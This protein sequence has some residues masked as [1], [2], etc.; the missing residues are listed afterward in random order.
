M[1]NFRIGSC[2]IDAQPYLH[3]HVHNTKQIIITLNYLINSIDKTKYNLIHNSILCDSVIEN[4]R[5]NLKNA[6]NIIIEI[7]SLKLWKDTN[8]NYIHWGNYNKDNSNYYENI[9]E[10]DF[11]NDLYIIYEILKDKNIIFVSHINLPLNNF[12]NMVE[13]NGE[14]RWLSNNFINKKERGCEDKIIKL[15]EIINIQYIKSRQ[16]IERYID[17]FI[18]K[19]NQTNIIHIKPYYI[20]KSYALHNNNTDLNIFF[21]INNNS[22]D[23][24]HYSEVGKRVICN[25]LNSIVI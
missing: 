18:Q 17:N 6:N 12:N 10:E 23:T 19:Y 8:H 20:L 22:I 9:S 25:Y 16:L 3:N 15:H 1:P 24:N 5:N 4:I 21:E 2:R 7:S 14:T 11:M 13:C